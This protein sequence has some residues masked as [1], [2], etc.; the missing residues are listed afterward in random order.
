MGAYFSNGTEGDAW[1]H[2]WC[3]TCTHD[4]GMHTDTGEGCP[5]F[6]RALVGETVPEWTTREGAPFILPPDVI[7]SAYE[8]CTLDDCTGDPQPEARAGARARV[9][10]AGS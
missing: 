7:C 4:H 8:P 2:V 1:Q 6:L 3:D 5:I 9:A 10:E